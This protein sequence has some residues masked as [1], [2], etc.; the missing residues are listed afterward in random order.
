MDDT[1]VIAL[2]RHGL[3]EANKRHAYLGWTD[4]PLC[5]I[6]KKK[7]KRPSEEY[8]YLFSSDLARCLETSK[9]LFPT[10][11]PH[12]LIELREM[13]FGEWEGKTYEDLQGDS[14]YQKWLA[15]PNLIRPTNGESFA[16]FSQRVELGWGKVVKRL[17]ESNVKRTV[18]MTHGGVIRSLLTKIAPMK[19]DFWEWET[20]H[21]KGYELVW[22]LNDLRRGERCTLLREVPLMANLNG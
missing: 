8:E 12:I 2:F 18:I 14:N 19:K 20:A 4:S 11:D 16:E 17:S 1:V 5:P 22:N 7:I 6:E 3:T 13:N 10:L 15:N 21:G 9:I